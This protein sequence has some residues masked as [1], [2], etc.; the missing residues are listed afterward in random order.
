[1][2]NI[3]QTVNVL[4]AVVLTEG[5][6]ILRTPTYHAFEMYIPFQEATFVP[7]MTSAV[8]A[9][10]FGEFSV[11]QVSA[12]AAISNGGDMVVALVNLHARDD[13]DVIV[14]LEGFDA[15]AAIG[16]VLSGDA[17]DSH[18]TFDDPDRVV[19]APLDVA[20]GGDEFRVSLPARS[21]SVITVSGR[22]N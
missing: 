8:P 18:N 20:L 11:P 22:L 17:I 10:E 16:R 13:I 7:F 15:T 14:A 4:Q 2:A 1:M 19:P 21:V 6:R 9:Y 3:A 5:R 12:T